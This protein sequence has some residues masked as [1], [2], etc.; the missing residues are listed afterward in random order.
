MKAKVSEFKIVA[1]MSEY[2][3]KVGEN[4]VPVEIEQY[5]NNVNIE[6]TDNMWIDVEI[7]KLYEKNVPVKVRVQGK[8]KEG[9][10]YL[11]PTFSQIDAVISG[12]D[13]YASIVN[14]VVADV[15]V[16][17]LSKDL[18]T[19]AQL[20]AVDKNGKNVDNVSI[21]PQK[22]TVTVPIK[23]SK[24]VGVNVVTV[25]KQASGIDIKSITPVDQSIDIIGDYDKVQDISNINTQ[26][27]D[28]SSISGSNVISVKLNLPEGVRTLSGKSSVNVKFN[29]DTVIQKT[30]ST[31]INVI[32][33]P[34]GYDSSLD[35]NSVNVTVS[36]DASVVNAV[37][38]GEITAT[39]DAS[40][41]KEGVNNVQPIIV[42]P[43]S[44]T[45]VGVT[46][47]SINVTLTK[48]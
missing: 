30:F 48:K 36:G 17:D 23:K 12:P 34:Q 37:N 2:A 1:D 15:N 26:P 42:V 20:Q 18:E 38:T 35:N 11:D 6:N 8:T 32:N 44:V 10:Y 27:I 19:E 45:N 4:R 25:G 29:V 14:N 16:E 47:A 24:T 46:P 9:Y 33:L 5:P 13:K 21:K 22:V 3:L 31:N 39:I 43:K 41:F 40:N 7:D 28:L